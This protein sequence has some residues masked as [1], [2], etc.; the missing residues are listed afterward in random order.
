MAKSPT[1]A[2]EAAAH[3]ICG[4]IMP[5][6][7]M[8]GYEPNHWP[9]VRRVIE[10]AIVKAGMTPQIVS[11]SF[12]SD[13]IQSRIINNLYYNP[14]VVCDVSGLNPNVMFELGMRITFKQP[15]VIITDSY[16]SIPFDTKIIE[17]LGYPR[18]LHIHKTSDFIEKLADKIQQLHEQKKSKS[19]T[20]FIE[21]FGTFEVLEPTEKA[22]PAE[23]LILDRLERIERNMARKPFAPVRVDGQRNLFTEFITFNLNDVGSMFIVKFKPEASPELV[24]ETQDYFD[25]KYRSRDSQLHFDEEAGVTLKFVFL[26]EIK[27]RAEAVTRIWSALPAHMAD[28]IETFGFGHL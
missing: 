14:V 11:D 13:V 24:K 12:E 6:A 21:A 25:R 15:V 16:D 19:Y 27:D 18:D 4:I 5:I 3:P 22:V 1:N 2:E 20:S 23:Q 8:P 10:S 7:A 17:H 26:D 9:D 28:Q